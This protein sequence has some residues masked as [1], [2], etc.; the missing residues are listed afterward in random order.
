LTEQARHDEFEHIVVK[1]GARRSGPTDALR[2]YW[3]IDVA[4]AL[5]ECGQATR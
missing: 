1:G 3:A 2:G 4:E 5:E